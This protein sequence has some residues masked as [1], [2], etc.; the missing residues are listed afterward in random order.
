MTLDISYN[1]K[2]RFVL[3]K[4]TGDYSITDVDDFLN[5]SV[6]FA[7]SIGCF[8][9]L[10]DHR[11]CQF[12]AETIGIHSVTKYLENYGF[13]GKFRGAVVYDQ[14]AEKYRFADTV[15]Q[16]WSMGILRFF[17]DFELAKKWLLE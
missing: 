3:V 6:D 5:K 15:S 7:R 12:I 11:D 13:D 8:R 1:K 10:Y 9:I 2:E 4:T 17:D 16:N 14:D